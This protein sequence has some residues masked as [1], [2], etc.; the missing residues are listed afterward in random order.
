MSSSQHYHK[1]PAILFLLAISFTGSVQL[2]GQELVPLPVTPSESSANN[3]GNP[4]DGNRGWLNLASNGKARTSSTQFELG[5]LVNKLATSTVIVIIICCAFLFLYKRFG[6]GSIDFKP[7]VKDDSSF[8]ILKT[9][10]LQHRNVLQLVEAEECRFVVGVD[11][12]GIKSIVPVTSFRTVL[13]SNEDTGSSI[14]HDKP[15]HEDSEHDLLI[16]MLS[17]GFDS[18]KERK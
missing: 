2:T 9:I 5:T 11:P 18:F 12:T 8:K 7:G 17:R 13:D 15:E 14:L 6:K 10:R 3:A 1:I 16:R 4:N